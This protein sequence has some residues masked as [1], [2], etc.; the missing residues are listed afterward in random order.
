MSNPNEP[1]NSSLGPASIEPW[2]VEKKDEIHVHVHVNFG[3]VEFGE[4]VEDKVQ[5]R[6]SLRAASLVALVHVNEPVV[7]LSS[8]TFRGDVNPSHK[9]FTEESESESDESK[10]K[11]NFDWTGIGAK[12]GFK[13]KDQNSWRR[14]T[15]KTKK[16][17][18]V[19]QG[20]DNNENNCW[21]FSCEDD[22]LLRGAPWD[23]SKQPLMVL[24]DMSP[25]S[26]KQRQSGEYIPSIGFQVICKRENFD[27]EDLKIKGKENEKAFSESETVAQN[28]R[29]AAANAFIR[30]ELAKRGL[31]VITEDQFAQ[32]FSKITVASRRSEIK[33]EK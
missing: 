18:S 15:N 33:V 22:V 4:S 20:R 5:F 25:S 30:S 2:F 13:Q 3:T 1:K 10:Q 28:R 7:V 14:R 11:L 17:I 31:S 32:Q 6:L 23:S 12:L 29:E 9:E 8:K 21:H 24:K 26:K 19:S 16:R 27:I